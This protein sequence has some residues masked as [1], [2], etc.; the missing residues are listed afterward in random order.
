M[1]KN[2]YFWKK[3]VKSPQRQPPALLLSSTAIAFVEC[4][5][6]IE[7]TLLL[8][9]ITEVTH[10]KCFGFVFPA[11][12]C[13]FFRFKLCSFWWWGRKSIFTSG[14]LVPWLRHW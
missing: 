4:V 8:R 1:L 13:L 11:L 9:K 3:A 2:A 6:S 10:S 12:L 5:S 7:H 14:R